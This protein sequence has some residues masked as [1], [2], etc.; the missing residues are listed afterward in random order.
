VDQTLP[1]IAFGFGIVMGITI[2][3]VSYFLIDR[4][5][6]QIDQQAEGIISKVEA[7]NNLI[8]Q[9]E[10]V[11]HQ[12][13]GGLN[14]TLQ[15]LTRVTQHLQSTLANERMRGAWGEQIAANVLDTAGFREGT[16]YNVRKSILT[17]EGNIFPDYT[18]VISKDCC[19]HMDAKFPWKNYEQL[20]EEDIS[21]SQRGEY[22]KRFVH[23][24]KKRI[25]EACKYIVKGS[26]SCVLVFIPNET[27]FHYLSEEETIR[28]HARKQKAVLC[29]PMSLLLVLT[30][31][32]EWSELQNINK[33]VH[34]IKAKIYE[35][36]EE[37][38]KDKDELERI[39]TDVKNI[40]KKIN[41]L[42]TR[43]ISNLDRKVKALENII[44]ANDAAQEKIEPENVR[45]GTG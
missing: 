40:E 14:T 12:Q 43:R 34:D 7:L 24:V 39:S 10:G 27:L 17:D 6:Q 37:V 25:D 32:R 9:Y 44:R 29:S 15:N 30:L 22:R 23:D 3:I 16:H 2:T 41:A 35:I 13:Y 26:L 20:F 19:V 36:V 42:G 8:N 45:D 18:F 21:E 31:I 1:F 5:K 38:R 4:R 33:A 28:E 11:R